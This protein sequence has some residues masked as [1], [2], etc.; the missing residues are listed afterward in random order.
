MNRIPSLLPAVLLSSLALAQA[1]VGDGTPARPPA[2]VVAVVDPV[3]VFDEFPKAAAGLKKLD[4]QRG[5]MQEQLK[6]A[7]RRLEAARLERDG[8]KPGSRDRAEKEIELQVLLKEYDLRKQFFEIDFDQKRD[9]FLVT[10]YEHI[11]KATAAVAKAKGID[12]VLRVHSIDSGDG[13]ST[14]KG[15]IY[16]RRVVWY[17]ADSVDLTPAVIKWLQ[18]EL[19]AEPKDGPKDATGD[20]GT[21]PA[22]GKK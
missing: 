4:E 22:D 17:A 16:E 2:T 12:V 9:E 20:K 3:K 11:E 18:I 14:T 1:P 8:L 13:S 19:P 7:E 10:I 6:K 5:A 21:T 15:R